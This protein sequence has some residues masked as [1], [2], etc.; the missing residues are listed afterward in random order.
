[1]SSDYESDV[2]IAP[3]TDLSETTSPV[4]R[5]IF[6]R[7][8]KA[9]MIRREHILLAMQTGGRQKPKY[10]TV[11]ASVAK[12]LDSIFALKLVPVLTKEEP[13]SKKRRTAAPSRPPMVLVNSLSSRSRA[14]LA[15][16]WADDDGQVPNNRNTNDAG[17]LIPKYSRT[18]TP[19]SN[20]DLVRLGLILLVVVLLVVAENHLSE[21]ELLRVLRPFGIPDSANKIIPGVNTN[22]HEL[23]AD[24][25]KRE[26][27]R[28]DG[29][30]DGAQSSYALGR[31][32]FVEYSPGAIFLCLKDIYGSGFTLATKRRVLATLE[33]SHG[34][35]VGI[36]DE[37]VGENAVDGETRDAESQNGQTTLREAGNDEE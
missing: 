10:D 3:N 25:A 8:L 31:R 1:M 4:I 7:S 20:A 37:E 15:K 19:A 35:T 33:R 26:Y 5:A 6:A 23:L 29:G 24:M 34:E 12:E 9:Q 17:F 22:V 14:V 28:V 18:A 32:A 36:D 2:E 21:D 16:M 30:T 11:M 13:V 27:I